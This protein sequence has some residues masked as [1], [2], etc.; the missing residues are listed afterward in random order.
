MVKNRKKKN[1]LKKFSYPTQILIFGIILSLFKKLKG[2]TR[3]VY[4]FL[5]V[6]EIFNGQIQ[7]GGIWG[8]LPLAQVPISLVLKFEI[9]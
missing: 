9:W 1:N 6:K 2:K 7:S 3:F 8:N 5:S 4:N